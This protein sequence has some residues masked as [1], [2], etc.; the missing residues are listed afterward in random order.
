MSTKKAKNILDVSVNSV[1][2]ATPR[3]LGKLGWNLAK[4][5]YG[6]ASRKRVREL[7][8]RV[9]ELEQQI[10]TEKYTETGDNE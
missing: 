10:Y 3:K 1:L 6:V 8:K 7:V 9:G 2:D 5:A 4:Y